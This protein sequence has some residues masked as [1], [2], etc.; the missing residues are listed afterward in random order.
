MAA[1]SAEAWVGARTRAVAVAVTAERT[2]RLVVTSSL[3][4]LVVAEARDVEMGEEGVLVHVPVDAGTNAEDVPS[5]RATIQAVE[6][7]IFGATETLASRRHVTS[8]R[9]VVTSSRRHVS[10]GS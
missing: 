4:L 5:R 6:I 7:F 9:H 10:L 3:S 8:R 1:A 2:S